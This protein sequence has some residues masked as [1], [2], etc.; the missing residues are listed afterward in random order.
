MGGVQK[1]D[2]KGNEIMYNLEGPINQSVFPGLQG[3]PHNHTI[4]A[5]ATALKQAASPEFKAYQEKVLSNSQAFA[6]A[7]TSRGSSLVSGGT[8][9][10]LLLVDLK[11][12]GID[13]ARVESVLEMANV[14]INKNTVPGDKSAFIPGGIRV[15]TPAL[16]SRGFVES[17]FETVAEFIHRGVQCAK[18][19]NASGI[20]KKLADFKVALATS[21]GRRSRRSRPTSRPSP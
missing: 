14:A 7:M 17:D 19:V 1:V 5:L 21:S 20:G 16:T 11:P 18:E 12:S 9:N 3:G 4:S 15:G 13:G 2:K 6:K 8:D 10:H